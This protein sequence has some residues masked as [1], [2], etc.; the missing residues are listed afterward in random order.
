MQGYFRDLQATRSVT[1]ADGWL[2]T[3]DMGYLVDG[4][5]VITGRS[6]DLII[7]NGRN[8]WPH[9]LEWAVERIE[10]VRPGDVAAF[11]LDGHDDREKVVVV[12]EC[13]HAGGSAQQ[14]LRQAV[15]ATVQ[16]AA[17]V[18]C[19]V[20]LAAP[21]SLTFTTSG[22][23]SRAAAKAKYLGGEIRDVAA[24]PSERTDQCSEMQVYAVAS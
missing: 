11:A 5:L 21:G 17:S 1:T 7:Y 14:T 15:R 18:E 24:S 2:D 8:I 12:V 6:K 20:V 10:G 4:E 19:E 16:R 23:L 13:R 3:G 22:K 9:D